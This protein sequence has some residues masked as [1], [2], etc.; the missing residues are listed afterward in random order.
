MINQD[1]YTKGFNEGYILAQYLPQVAVDLT[2]I[3]S[4]HPRISGIQDGARWYALE[5]MRQKHPSWLHGKNTTPGKFARNKG[6]D[7]E[8]DR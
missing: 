4:E 5:Q 1:T 8:P 6:K 3:K 7:R 2:R